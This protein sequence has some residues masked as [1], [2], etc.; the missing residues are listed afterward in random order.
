MFI[1]AARLTRR[2]RRH[3]RTIPTL[4]TYVASANKWE[5]FD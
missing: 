2:W 5:R 4:T 1:L 3:L